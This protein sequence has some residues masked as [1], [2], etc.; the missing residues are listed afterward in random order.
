MISIILILLFVFS[1]LSVPV[2]HGVISGLYLYGMKIFPGLFISFIL[3]NKVLNDFLIAL[4]TGMIGSSLTALL[5]DRSHEKQNA[6]I[7]NMMKRKILYDM[8]LNLRYWIN[9]DDPIEI[10]EKRHDN[11]Y[12]D[13][14][15]TECQRSLNFAIP[16][17][18]SDEYQAISTIEIQ[19]KNISN[20]MQKLHEKE[21]YLHYKDIY[22]IL[23]YNNPILDNP[24]Y[25]YQYENRL[26]Q[27]YDIASEVAYE[28]CM[29]V[30]IHNMN[31]NYIKNQ[32][33]LFDDIETENV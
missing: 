14:R 30:I 24:F 32:L 26:T 13:E 28:I 5:I 25:S 3:T 11:E 29:S 4:G 12:I 8:L 1:V 17:L 20:D 2:C 22:E 9:S 19:L 18:S 7:S 6:V 10:F 16:F 31:I 15:I 21:H 27:L 33:Q 23:L